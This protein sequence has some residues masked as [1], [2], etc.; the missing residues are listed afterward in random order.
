MCAP[1]LR[2]SPTGKVEKIAVIGG[3]SSEK[4]ETGSKT[5]HHDIVE[6]YDIENNKWETG[7]HLRLCVGIPGR[8]QYD[9]SRGPPSAKKTVARSDF[10]PVYIA[11]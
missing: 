6:I 10:G 8:R 1:L 9:N 3:Y 4:T 5:I 7:Q 2:E 11:I